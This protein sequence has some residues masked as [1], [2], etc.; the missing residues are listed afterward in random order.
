MF[1][2]GEDDED[3]NSLYEYSPALIA[4]RASES[5][6]DFLP[7]EVRI[8]IAYIRR[9]ITLFTKRAYAASRC[10]LKTVFSEL[11]VRL[12]LTGE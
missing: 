3:E 2:A 7:A 10:I 4:R 12:K 1:W 8:F 6:I 11:T 5:W 9:E